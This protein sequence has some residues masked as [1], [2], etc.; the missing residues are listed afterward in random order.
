MG[1][2]CSD[3]ADTTTTAA[4]PEG[5]TPTTQPPT[6][7]TTTAAPAS[8]STDPVAEAVPEP[9]PPFSQDSMNPGQQEAYSFVSGSG[10][11]IEYLLYVP[12][13]YEESRAWPLILSLHGFLGRGDQTLELVRPWN[14]V[15]WVDP[16]VEFPFVVVA[17]LGPSG[18]WSQY[19]EPM[20]E[21][22]GVL[23]EAMSINQEALFLT[24]W[25]AGAIGTWQWALARPDQF[26][27]IAP[28]AG[29]LPG[30]EVPV[31]EDICRL[32]DLPIWV[33][34]SEAD[35]EAPIDSDAAIVAEL[36]ECGSTVVRFTVYEDLGHVESLSSAYA[37]PDLYEWML[38]QVP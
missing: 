3:S 6:T 19:H 30:V 32:V 5:I 2:A 16:S 20:D 26:A 28:I 23:G 25:S 35:E 17:P 37:G 27:G 13:G 7:T 33:A 15:A 38:E 21:L 12:E 22:F 36:E 9:L 1:T 11:E 34:R 10:V 14:P 4:V 29:G 31:P 24:G 18:L 8:T